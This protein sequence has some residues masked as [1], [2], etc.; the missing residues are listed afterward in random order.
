MVLG[1]RE[2]LEDLLFRGGAALLGER[3]QRVRSPAVD[4]AFDLLGLV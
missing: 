1:E 3:L 2:S 4:H